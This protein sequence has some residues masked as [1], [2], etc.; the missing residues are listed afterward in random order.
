MDYPLEVTAFSKGKGQVSFMTDGYDICHNTDEVIES[1]GD[2]KTM[3]K[4]NT[5]NSVFCGHGAGVTVLWN[6]ADEKMH[7]EINN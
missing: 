3:D 6:E 7:C 4:E 1:I 2:D 5:P